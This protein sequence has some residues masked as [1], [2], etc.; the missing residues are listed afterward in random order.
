MTADITTSPDILIA[1][2]GPIGCIV[3]EQAANR[4]A[5]TVLIVEKRNHIA[6]NCFDSY[7][8][9][10]ILIHNYGPHYFRTGYLTLA[11]EANPYVGDN[12][13]D[14][15]NGGFDGNTT[16]DYDERPYSDSV[17]DFYIIHLGSGLDKKVGNPDT[18]Y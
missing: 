1:G 11:Q 4:L 13:P 12:A 14:P 8:E 2:A 9:S 5:L 7:H 15:D 6:G 3:A 16:G 18:A 10:G 17:P